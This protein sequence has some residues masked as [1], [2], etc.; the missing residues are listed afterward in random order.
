[1]YSL[2]YIGFIYKVG[3]FVSRKWFISTDNVLNNTAFLF[4][5]RNK[6][7][8]KGDIVVGGAIGGAIFGGVLGGIPG[9]LI[10]A[11]I[12]AAVGSQAS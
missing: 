4:G 9:A 10:G 6:H 11:L 12:G 2:E 3:Y 8:E 5:M 1:M 7:V